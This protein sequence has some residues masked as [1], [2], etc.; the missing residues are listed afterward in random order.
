M[1]MDE[2]GIIIACKNKEPK[3]QKALFDSYAYGMLVVCMRYVKHQP[4]AEELMLNGFYKFFT[5]IDQFVYTGTGTI[6]PWLKKIMINECLMFLRKKGGLQIADEDLAAELAA[7]DDIIAR[8]SAAE[9]FELVTMLPVGYRTVFN[10]Y[11]VEGM[12]HKEIAGVLGV[13]EGTSKSQLN[14]ARMM[15]QKEMKRK[16]VHYDK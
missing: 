13:S 8:L 9:I 10:L 14:K 1:W 3:A 5:H 15:L 12:S 2:A 16:G 11:V 4:D 7:G 6:A